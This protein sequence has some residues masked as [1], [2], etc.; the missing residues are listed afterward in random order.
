M[1][2]RQIITDN[3]E[4]NFYAMDCA[5]AERFRS[6]TEENEAFEANCIDVAGGKRAEIRIANPY[7]H[8]NITGEAYFYNIEFTGEDMFAS[9]TVHGASMGFMD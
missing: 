7:T 8:F 6:S 3:V 9:A 5:L 2:R 4:L 1:V